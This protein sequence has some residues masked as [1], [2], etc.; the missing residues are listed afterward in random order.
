MG[1]FSFLSNGSLKKALRQGAVII[2]VRSASEYDRGRVP[3]SLNIPV[4]RIGAS[5]PR[6]K[7]LNKPV[8]CVCASGHRSRIAADTLK[9]A[10]LKEVYNGGSWERILRLI[11][12]L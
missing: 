10:G 2:D 1:L 12:S 5:I 4:D 11:E 8:I 9:Q 3:G 6:I 7:G